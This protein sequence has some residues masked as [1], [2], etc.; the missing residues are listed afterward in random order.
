MTNAVNDEL[1]SSLDYKMRTTYQQQSDK[2][3]TNSSGDWL[4]SDSIKTTMP[5]TFRTA[6]RSLSEGANGSDARRAPELRQDASVTAQSCFRDRVGRSSGCGALEAPT[7]PW[8]TTFKTCE[9]W[10][11]RSHLIQR[12]LNPS[13]VFCCSVAASCSRILQFTRG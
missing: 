6:G 9:F 7:A 3:P 12:S 13:I 8:T 5:L 2:N 10:L 11:R 1:I 4:D